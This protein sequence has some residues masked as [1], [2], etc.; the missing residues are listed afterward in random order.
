M[1]EQQIDQMS[2]IYSEDINEQSAYFDGIYNFLEDL[3]HEPKA[4]PQKGDTCLL[5]VSNHFEDDP[6]EDYF[7]YVTSTWNGTGWTEDHFS[8]EADVTVYHWLSIKD[9]I[10]P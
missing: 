2:K 3:W 8:S 4:T 5:Y 1:T 9:I 10:F 6:E 7:E